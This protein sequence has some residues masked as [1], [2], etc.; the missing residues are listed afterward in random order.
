MDDCNVC[1]KELK[2]YIY[3]EAD[4]EQFVHL[5]HSRQGKTIHKLIMDDTT[6]GRLSQ[7]HLVYFFQSL[8]KYDCQLKASNISTRYKEHDTIASPTILTPFQVLDYVPS[9][10]KLSMRWF[11]TNELN[12]TT[13]CNQSTHITHLNLVLCHPI[14]EQSVQNIIDAS[15]LLQS[16]SIFYYTLHGTVT[17][18]LERN[19]KLK[20]VEYHAEPGDFIGITQNDQKKWYTCCR[21]DRFEYSLKDEPGK[22]D[23]SACCIIILPPT[24]RS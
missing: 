10:V 15:P 23:N 8:N 2:V 14:L 6:D 11:G 4:M 5:A 3:G 21:S 19:T 9:L 17:L 1:L 16:F 24:I 13:Y 12:C 20:F 18:D 22:K 7:E